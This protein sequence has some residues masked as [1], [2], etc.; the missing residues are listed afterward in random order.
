MSSHECK[1]S[2]THLQM[3]LLRKERVDDMVGSTRELLFCLLSVIAATW[4]VLP[5]AP[6]ISSSVLG[7]TPVPARMALT[8]LIYF[9][10]FKIIQFDVTAG[11]IILQ[12]VA[13]LPCF[14]EFLLPKIYFC[15]LATTSSL[16]GER[17]YCMLSHGAV[18]VP[19]SL[20]N[21]LARTET[22]GRALLR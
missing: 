9:C 20:Q 18:W 16:L 12:M 5:P 14:R 3:Q 1:V 6:H 11:Q 13:I 2:P 22:G 15:F 7:T 21:T 17:S 19:F 8:S 10:F 4:M